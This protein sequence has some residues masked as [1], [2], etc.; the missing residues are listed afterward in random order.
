MTA[1]FTFAGPMEL[2]AI[3]LRHLK[4]EAVVA[5]TTLKNIALFAIA[6]FIGLVYAMALP[7]V[8]LA[9]LAWIGGKALVKAPAAY[10]ALIAARNVVL[11]AVA[12]LIGLVYAVALP[13]VGA[14]LIARVGYQAYRVPVL[15]A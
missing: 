12:P 9:M 3:E 7:F 6:P 15:A 4:A 13:F 1:T 11:F 5:A 8:G 14:A 10:R 2:P